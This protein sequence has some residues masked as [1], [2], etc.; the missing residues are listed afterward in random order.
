MAPNVRYDP[1]ASFC[2]SLEIDGM[3]GPKEAFFK[4]ISGLKSETEVVPFREGGLNG[5]THQLVG[6][7]KWP[8]LVL[9]R[10]F[11]KGDRKLIQWRNK[12]TKPMGDP[13]QALKRLRGKIIQLDS[14]MN[15][16][17][18]WVFLDGWPCRWEGP[19]YDAS[20]SEL[21]VETIE[22]AHSGLFFRDPDS[23][24]D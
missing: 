9:K 16:V 2:F 20:K 8:N 24:E 21:A 11:V 19:E 6:A 14:K 17:C 1:L 22:I 10:G 12:W 4:S 3:F 18:W 23:R 15:P 7:T 13:P 5:H